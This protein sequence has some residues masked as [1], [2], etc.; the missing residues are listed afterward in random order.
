M[1]TTG[2]A[3]FSCAVIPDLKDFPFRKKLGIQLYSLRDIINKQP[4]AVL[5]NLAQIGF[6]EIE[7]YG[8]TDGK[9]YG[10]TPGK[11]QQIF[12]KNY[13]KSPSGHYGLEKMLAGDFEELKEVIAVAKTLEQ[14]YI[15]VPSIP[16][17]LRQT[18]ADYKTIARRLNRAGELC[19]EAD[20][21]IAYHNHDFEF[22]KL[23]NSEY[24]GYE[25]LLQHTNQELVKFEMD[26]YWVV[27]SGLDPINVLEQFPGR[28]DLLHIKDMDK[29]NQDLNTEIGN[30]SID[31]QEILKRISNKSSWHY[32]IEQEN[33]NKDYYAS[34]K[35]SADY[36]AKII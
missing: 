1:K 4:E 19:K 16:E 8:L 20:L 2:L 21:K 18:A 30:G 32:I 5:E 23:G 6:T 36:L 33:F 9:M 13:L 26:V 29:T 22:D 25:I 3:L 12:K 11:L 31:Y 10:L 34:L 15:T 7:T 35:Q 24:N 17:N 28:F 27:R 14:E